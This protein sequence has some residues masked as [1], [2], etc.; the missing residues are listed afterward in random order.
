M[1][2]KMEHCKNH[3]IKKAFGTCRYCGEYFC[4]DCLLIGKEYNCCSKAEC[5][6]LNDA[7]LLP[8]EVTCPKC[9]AEM[10]LDEKERM[11]DWV[12][13]SECDVSIDFSVN[14][15]VVE[16][17]KN[18]VEIAWSLNQADISLIKSI[19][20][21]TE[22]DYYVLGENFMCVDPLIQPARIFVLDEQTVLV[23]D[24]LKDFKVQIVGVSMRDDMTDEG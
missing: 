12:H 10:I 23:K 14:P 11:S 22:I 9:C 18:Y 3:P 17:P 5:M 2:D 8:K 16:E 7:K 19:L 1:E 6:K 15:P 24:I 4:K 13:C 21:D 20:D